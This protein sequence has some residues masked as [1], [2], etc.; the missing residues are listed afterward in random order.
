MA[1][2]NCQHFEVIP[3][4]KTVTLEG[5]RFCCS[6]TGISE[7]ASKAIKAQTSV[8]SIEQGTVVGQTVTPLIVQGCLSTDATHFV[9][10]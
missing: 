3:P 7:G 8:T 1:P 6:Q 9:Y 4:A 2:Y 5:K 10:S